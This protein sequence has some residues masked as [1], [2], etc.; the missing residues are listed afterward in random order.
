MEYVEQLFSKKN[1]LWL[2]KLPKKYQTNQANRLLREIKNLK[3][4]DI[5]IAEIPD[6]F[7]NGCDSDFADLE[8]W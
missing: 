2:L 4:V 5:T 7:R 1:F 8:D 3:S 6:L